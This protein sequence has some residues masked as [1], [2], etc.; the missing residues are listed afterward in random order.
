MRKKTTVLSVAF[1][2]LYMIPAPGP[3]QTIVFPEPQNIH[4][5]THPCPITNRPP[6]LLIASS[7]A[8]QG[9]APERAELAGGRSKTPA[10]G[11][12][13]ACESPHSAYLR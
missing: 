8:G 2:G 3:G 11:L 7:L 9:L 6:P 13:G 1:G 10:A 5:A 12:A 4:A